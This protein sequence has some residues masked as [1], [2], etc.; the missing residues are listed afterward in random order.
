MHAHKGKVSYNTQDHNTQDIQGNFKLTSA[1]SVNRN[2]A[3]FLGELLLYYVW[4]LINLLFARLLL[5]FPLFFYPMTSHVTKK[6]DI[7]IQE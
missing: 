1:S 4:N 6:T 5:K 2:H 7:L 3:D